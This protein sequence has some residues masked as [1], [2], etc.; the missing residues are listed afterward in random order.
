MARL[1]AGARMTRMKTIAR[2]TVIIALA[3]LVGACASGGQKKPPV[4]A[5]DPDKFLFDRGSESLGR[6]KWIV[7]REYFRQLINVD[8][9]GAEATQNTRTEE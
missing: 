8:R 6:K 4:G 5:P 9:S 2:L 7:A 3:A 1:D